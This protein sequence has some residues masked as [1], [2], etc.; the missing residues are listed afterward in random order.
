MF[1]LLNVIVRQYIVT[2]LAFCSVI[3]VVILSAAHSGFG[4]LMLTVRRASKDIQDV[5]LFALIVTVGIDS[6]SSTS[7][8]E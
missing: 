3:D 2:P 5:L 1:S 6:S 4:I 8:A 7:S